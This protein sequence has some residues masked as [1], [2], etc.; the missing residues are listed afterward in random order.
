MPKRISPNRLYAVYKG[1]ELICVGT[2]KECAEFTGMK[3]STINWASS[4]AA[5]KRAKKWKNAIEVYKWEIDP[6]EFEYSEG[7]EMEV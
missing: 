3:E 6:A 4:P 2:A 5:L 1:D 7:E